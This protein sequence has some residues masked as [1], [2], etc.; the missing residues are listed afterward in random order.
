MSFDLPLR[1]WLQNQTS[2][3]TVAAKNLSIGRSRDDRVS[4]FRW[5]PIPE[6]VFACITRFLSVKDILRLERVYIKPLFCL[7]S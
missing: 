3:L 7:V 6:D 2:A 4:T 5:Q 1:A